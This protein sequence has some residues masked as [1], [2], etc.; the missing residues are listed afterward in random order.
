[1]PPFW[2]ENRTEWNSKQLMKNEMKI[3][4]VMHIKWSRQRT[5]KKKKISRKECEKNNEIMKKVW[6]K[7]RRLLFHLMSWA[8]VNIHT[9]LSLSS[10][11]LRLVYSSKQNAKTCYRRFFFVFYTLLHGRYEFLFRFVFVCLFNS[12]ETRVLRSQ[13]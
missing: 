7:Q 1:M 9:L 12:W 4:F 3:I 13:L 2:F 11:Q 5:K 8:C 6:K 10:R